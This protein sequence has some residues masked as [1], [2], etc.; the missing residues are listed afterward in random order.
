M[1][2]FTTTSIMSDGSGSRKKATTNPAQPKTQTTA[3]STAQKSAN[4]RQQSNVQT[5]DL[6]YAK[7]Q[8]GW[9]NNLERVQQKAAVRKDAY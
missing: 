6:V 2:I 3:V 4:Y 9:Q 5:Q 1:A 8:P 7:S